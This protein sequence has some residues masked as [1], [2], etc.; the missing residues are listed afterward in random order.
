MKPSVRQTDDPY[1]DNSKALV[2]THLGLARGLSGIRDSRQGGRTLPEEGVLNVTYKGCGQ[3]AFCYPPIR[4]AIN[5]SSLSI[6]AR[7]SETYV[8]ASNTMVDP[9]R[10]FQPQE[11]ASEL[12]C[13]LTAGRGTKAVAAKPGSTRSQL[14]GSLLKFGVQNG[15]SRKTLEPRPD[16]TSGE[17]AILQGTRTTPECPLQGDTT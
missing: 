13:Q 3:D 9:A 5:L 4:K 14:P 10:R 6:G 7:P 12:H 2:R 11:V 1:E 15:R 8:S 17:N 16:A